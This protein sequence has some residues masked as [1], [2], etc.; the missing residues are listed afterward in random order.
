MKGFVDFLSSVSDRRKLPAAADQPGAS[1][2]C[3]IG[4]MSKHLQSMNCDELFASLRYTDILE[5]LAEIIQFLYVE[6]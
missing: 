2:P 5:E 4:N 1:L 6:K 3:R